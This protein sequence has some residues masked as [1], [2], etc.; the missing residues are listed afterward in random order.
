MKKKLIVSIIS[1]VLVLVLC[2]L[3]I[4]GSKTKNA[5]PSTEIN[6]IEVTELGEGS[7][8]FLFYVVDGAGNTSGYQI[9][10]E[11]KTVGAA[12]LQLNLISGE[13]GAYG[14]YVKEVNGIRADYDTDGC[15]WA[16]Y[17]DGEYATSGVDTTE[18]VDGATYTFK[19][20]K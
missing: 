12:L 3:C 10:T 17:I 5:S 16:F 14:L 1:A 7:R 9:D 6:T 11:E 13:E 20:E 19:V 2:T 18:I 4:W 8:E 15:Y